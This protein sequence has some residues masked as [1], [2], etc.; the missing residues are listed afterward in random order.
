MTDQD[1]LIEQGIRLQNLIN[2]LNTNGKSFA[3][4]ISA[5]QSHVSQICSGKRRITVD[6]LSKI[7]SRY[8]NV[9]VS[10]LLYGEGQTFKQDSVNESKSE[11][12]GIA[13]TDLTVIASNIAVIRLRW[14]FD[15][16][17]FGELLGGATRNKVSNWERARTEP[18]YDILSRLEALTGI[19]QR[20]IRT[21]VLNLNE[22]PD[23]PLLAAASL[24]AQGSDIEEVYRLQQEILE[25]VAAIEEILRT[26]RERGHVGPT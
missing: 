1:Q 26:W 12:T 8:P 14:R 24:S 4:S 10:W 2:A 20:R 7:T 16:D 22:I 3:K 9:N 19:P 17:K 18:D 21:Q 6:F 13:E 23:L 25:R 15:Q 5:V 11:I